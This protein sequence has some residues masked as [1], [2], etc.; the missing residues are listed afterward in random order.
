MLIVLP[1]VTSAQCN[2]SQELCEKRYD[3]VAYLTTHNAF[4]ASSEGFNLANQTYGL[5]QQLEDGVRALMLDVY[6][7][8]GVATVYHGFSFLGTATL[9]SN[10]TEIK[11]FL[12]ANPNEVVTLLFETYISANMMD[13]VITNAGLKSMLHAQTL[14]E[15]WPTLQEMIAL[16][17][18]LVFFSDHNNAEIG[19]DWYHYMWDFI[20]ETD[21][22]NH[23]PNDFSCGF[24]RGNS[25]NDLFIVN[26]FV[27]DATFGTGQTNQASVVNELTYFYD[28][29][30]GCQMQKQKFVNFPTV[31]FYELGQTLA[32]V[33]SLNNT[34]ISMGIEYEHQ[35]ISSVYPN[36]SNGV[37]KVEKI[38]VKP[39][40]NYQLYNLSGKLIE[41]GTFGKSLT[42]NLTS[43]PA[44][45][46]FLSIDNGKEAEFHRLLSLPKQ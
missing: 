3:E 4:N 14:G 39:I 28:R 19:Q 21:F 42:L 27:T 33:D 22:E 17:K 15:P 23:S 18:R 16:D 30:Y 7:E 20:V 43:W 40:V 6:D 45:V 29:V 5:T 24:N 46:Y 35:S 11:S 2:G 31:D 10:L 37:F 44:G 41:L 13:T 1:F 25:N 12:D 26:H 32:V 8:E 9:E 34:Q 38:G 36:P